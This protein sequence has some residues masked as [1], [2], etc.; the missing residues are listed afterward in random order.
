MPATFGN[1]YQVCFLGFSKHIRG[2]LIMGFSKHV[3]GKL[4][5]VLNTFE[6]MIK[7]MQRNIKRT[8]YKKLCSKINIALVV[9]SQLKKG[10]ID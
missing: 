3:Q 10:D 5:W 7:Y 2:K 8:T 6:T 4:I 1:E 9:Y